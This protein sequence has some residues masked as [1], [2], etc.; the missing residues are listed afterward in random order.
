MNGTNVD[1]EEVSWLNINASSQISSW[2]HE[3]TLRE[4]NKALRRILEDE[5]EVPAAGAEIDEVERMNR[6]TEFAVNLRKAQVKDVMKKMQAARRLDLCF[7]VDVT[8][9]MGPHITGVKD[10]IRSIVDKLTTKPNLGTRSIVNM[11]CA[12]RN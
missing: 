11:V 7:L 8:S 2:T 3:R 9:S 5:A 6:R 10:S 1:D 4:H 12:I